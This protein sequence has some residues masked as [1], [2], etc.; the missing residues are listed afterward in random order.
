TLE[1]LQANRTERPRQDRRGLKVRVG[2]VART[3]EEVLIVRNLEHGFGERTLYRGVTFTLQRGERLAIIG[4]NGAGKTTLLKTFAGE[5]TPLKGEVEFGFRVQ[6][7]YFAQDL[8]LLDADATVW[9][10]IWDT[11]ALDK[12]STIQAL[13]Q[14]L[15]VAEALE[16]PVGALSGGE[17]T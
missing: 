13:Q 9:D 11:G 14:F 10:T 7:A 17:R 3:G 2:E 4:P 1:K 15:F 8:S 6:P 12:P 5:L 16:K